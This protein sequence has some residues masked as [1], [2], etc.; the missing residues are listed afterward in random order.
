MSIVVTT[1]LLLPLSCLPCIVLA[2]A[3]GCRLHMAY[4]NRSRRTRQAMILGR[5]A[6]VAGNMC[7]LSTNAASCPVMLCRC[8]PCSA[9][10]SMLCAFVISIGTLSNIL[11]VTL[12]HE[13]AGDR[14]DSAVVENREKRQNA[15]NT[16][17]VL[18]V[19]SIQ[20]TEYRRQ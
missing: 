5:K 6:A 19:G 4:I 13:T 14:A 15:D 20:H 10:S 11:S 9:G 1:R 18:Y 17:H 12:R 2:L 7:S 8:V 3:E 16:K